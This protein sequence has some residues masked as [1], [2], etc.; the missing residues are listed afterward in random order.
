MITFNKEIA[1]LQPSKSMTFMAKAKQMQ[2][3][4][5]T[6]INLAGGEPD[7]ATPKKICDELFR[8][9]EAG[10]TH[11]TV[12]PGLP[13]LREK[14]A[15]KL[16][17]ENGCNYSPEGV[18]V[19]PGGKFAIYLAVRSLVN[20]GDEVMYLEPGW[21]SYP[22]IIEASA[23]LPVPVRLSL[24]NNYKVTLEQL[25]QFVTD[26][27]KVLIIN[28][29]NNPTGKTL[30]REEAGEVEQFM[31]RHPDVVLIA[32]EIYERIVFTGYSNVSMASYPSIADRVVTVNGFSKSVAMTGW[33]IGYL[34]T[35][36]EIKNVM[37]KLFQHTMSCVSGFIQKA[38]VVALDCKDEIEEM[39]QS[40][41]RRRDLFVGGLNAIDSVQC[42]Y[43][44]GAFYAWV[45]FDIPGLDSEGVC[46]YILK[47]AKVVGV[48]GVAYGT[49]DSCVRFS[50]ASSEEDLKQAVE[51]I[52]AVMA[53][54]KR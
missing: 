16:A 21:V 7:F 13:E 49:D 31:L 12:G 37:N 23:A 19:T 33:R 54:V 53:A 43:P 50:F 40:Y 10:Y 2:A 26:K 39:R 27:T 5:P 32:D 24:E 15:K 52:G 25:E 46:E 41:E 17:E 22:A 44:E 38:A 20:A 14:I 9:V 18:I 28:Y 51:R 11:Y 30:S 8:Q 45:K 35:T 34:A 1:N 48:P 42:S 4:D 6:V 3:T 29:P 47:E 36:P